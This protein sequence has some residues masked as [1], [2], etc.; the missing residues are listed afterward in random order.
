M[1]PPLPWITKKSPPF[2]VSQ[3]DHRR[4]LALGYGEWVASLD[5]KQGCLSESE[6]TAAC[7]VSVSKR[8]TRLLFLADNC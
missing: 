8:N 3:P 1:S 5:R 6:E 2:V 4:S 7:S